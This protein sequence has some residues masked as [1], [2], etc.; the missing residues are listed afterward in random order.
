MLLTNLIKTH[1]NKV[2]NILWSY[3]YSPVNNDWLAHVGVKGMKWGYSDGKANGGR[4]PGEDEKK[5]GT[6]GSEE[7]SKKEEG[8][9]KEEPIIEMLLEDED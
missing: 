4:K 8:K 3:N 2:V 5:S 6:S 1:L 7:T 9:K